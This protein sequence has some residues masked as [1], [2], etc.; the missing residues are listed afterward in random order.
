[1]ARLHIACITLIVLATIGCDTGERINRLEKEN[2]ELKAKLEKEHLALDYD[3]QAKCSKDARVWF[4]GGWPMS[5]SI[6]YI[7]LGCPRSGFSDLGDHEPQ[8]AF[9]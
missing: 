1:M 6:N 8:P 3:L 5:H 2:V 7:K 9:F 4:N